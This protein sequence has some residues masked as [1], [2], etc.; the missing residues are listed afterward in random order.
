[1]TD[2]GSIADADWQVWRSFLM[3]RKQLDRALEQRLQ[4]DAGISGAD[5]EVLMTL[6]SAH[7]RQLRARDLTELLGWEK[8]RVSHQVTRMAARGLVERQDCPTDLRGTWVVL[9]PAGRRAALRAMRGHNEELNRLF[10]DVLSAEEKAAFSGVSGRIIDAVNPS[11]CERADAILAA[12][13][14]DEAAGA[15][16]RAS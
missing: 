12:S 6:T 8:S 5:F 3:M 2:A 1:M 14:P 13:A 10:F 7:E 9:L 15:E 16:A 11:A 4:G